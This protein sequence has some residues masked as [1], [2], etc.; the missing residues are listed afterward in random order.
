MIFSAKLSPTVI[1]CLLKGSEICMDDLSS[2]P[3]KIICC[4][5]M[6]FELL[7]KTLC[8]FFH[9]AFG[10]LCVSSTRLW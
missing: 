7:C 4:L 3:L 10:S 1:K 5:T 6:R 2:V 9:L 8:I